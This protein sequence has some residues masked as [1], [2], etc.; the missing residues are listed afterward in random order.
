[1]IALAFQIYY[2]TRAFKSG[3]RFRVL[4]PLSVSFL[5]SGFLGFT[6][7]LTGGDVFSLWPV[8]L[9]VDVTTIFLLRSMANSAPA[10]YNSLPDAADGTL[11]PTSAAW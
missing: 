10:G 8:G 11:A 9:A 5:I 6:A 1:M 7:A 4:V 2:A 3:W